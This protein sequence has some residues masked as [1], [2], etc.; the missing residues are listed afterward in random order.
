MQSIFIR[1][2]NFEKYKGRRDVTHNSWFRCSNRLLED[3]DFFE[4]SH[5]ELLVWIYILS[6][7]SQKNTDVIEVN[8][9]HAERVCRLKKSIVQKAMQKLMGKQILPVDVTPTLRESNADDTQ[10]CATIHN[11]TIQTEQNNTLSTEGAA[12]PLLPVGE[13]IEYFN[14]FQEIAPIKADL[15]VEWLKVY[16]KEWIEEELGKAKRWCLTNPTKK[17]KSNPGNFLNGWLSRNWDS[18]RKTIPPKNP[19]HMSDEEFFSGIRPK[20]GA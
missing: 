17:P 10:T 12:S 14:F 5:P 6:L 3:P 15:V 2:V 16:P 8:F 18:F 1:V 11:N 19:R 13:E 9:A 7:T 20:A 4:F